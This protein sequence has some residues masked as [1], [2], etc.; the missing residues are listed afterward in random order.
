MCCRG[1]ESEV[2]GVL[3]AETCYPAGKT[4]AGILMWAGRRDKETKGALQQ[5][6]SS[7]ETAIV[8]DLS[9]VRSCDT[10]RSRVSR[11]CCAA[12]RT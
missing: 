12:S 5:V 7:C 8:Y 11:H 1:R 6:L 3:V 9:T 10:E 2:N 4:R